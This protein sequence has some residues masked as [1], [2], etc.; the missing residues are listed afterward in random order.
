MKR[1]FLIAGAGSRSAERI[2]AGIIAASV[3]A[4]SAGVGS[5]GRWRP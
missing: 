3:I 4:A 5:N 1:L 2:V